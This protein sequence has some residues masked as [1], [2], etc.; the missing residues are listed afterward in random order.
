MNR[1]ARVLRRLS[2][3]MVILLPLSAL[4]AAPACPTIGV[5]PTSLPDGVVG[6]AYTQTLSATT[7]NPPSAFA[8]A[9]YGVDSGVLPTGLAINAGQLVGTPT[10][11]GAFDFAISASDAASCSGSRIYRVSVVCGSFTIAPPTH[12]VVGTAYNQTLVA[13]GGAAPYT[14]ALDTASPLLPT[15]LTLASDGTLS[16][17]AQAGSGGSYALQ[18]DVSDASSCSNAAVAVTLIVDESPAFTSVNSTTFTVGSAGS[19]LVTATGYPAPTLST[20][21]ALPGGVTFDPLSGVLA[22][23]PAAGS[24]GTYPVTF[25]ATNSLGTTTQNF[26]LTV[27]DAPTFTSANAATF[28]VGT[29]GTFTVTASGS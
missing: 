1:F 26:T 7:G 4:A 24:A 6:S 23:T 17:T 20:G 14:F 11:T 9:A 19:F 5:G 2:S 28:T 27:T 18:I 15:G 13:S 10:S 29:S 12:A 21:S 22:G 16:G 8:P 3:V 25:S